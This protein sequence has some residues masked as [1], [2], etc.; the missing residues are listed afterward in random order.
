[1][2]RASQQK[3]QRQ[4]QKRDRP[5][6]IRKVREQRDLLHVLGETFDAGV[7][8]V[9][10]PLATA[11]RVLVHDTVSS[12]SLL[13]QL[14]ELK[15]MPFLDTSLPINPQ[16][17]LPHAG[18]VV[19][20][21]TMGS[22]SDWVPRKEVPQPPP[23]AEPREVPFSSWWTTDLTKDGSG[24]LW[25]RRRMVLTI[26]NKEGGA[27]IDPTQPI[28]I[29]A[30]EEENSMGWTHH[31]PIVGDKPMSKGPMMP[32]LRQIGYELEVGLTNYFGS[33]LAP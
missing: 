11:I 30:I 6:L 9:G 20:R 28:D 14:D 18:L 33:E 15:A 13:G 17:L 31:D 21:M 2:G 19:M 26:A 7:T 3:E 4:A 10:F 24:V 1:M 16:N 29:R 23:G 12:H 5:Q 8:V 25:S 32:S 22:G 27:H